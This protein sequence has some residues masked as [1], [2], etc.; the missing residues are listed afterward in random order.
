KKTFL[1]YKKTFLG[2]KKT[3]LGYK[4]TFLGYKKTGFSAVL[5]WYIKNYRR[6]RASLGRIWRVIDPPNHP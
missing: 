4:K 5:C 3:F 6:F 1:G 2:Y